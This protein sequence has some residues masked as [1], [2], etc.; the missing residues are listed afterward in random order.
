MNRVLTPLPRSIALP[1]LKSNASL[2][3]LFLLVQHVFT[4]YT[5]LRRGL[6]SLFG[7][8]WMGRAFSSAGM[9]DFPLCTTGRAD[10]CG[11][12]TLVM[13]VLGWNI[14]EA[15]MA[16]YYPTNSAAP[17]P[18]SGM[19]MGMGTGMGMKMTPT[20]MSSPLV[21]LHALT[22]YQKAD[23]GPKTRAYP[24]P[25]RPGSSLA[26]SA[27][28]STPKSPTAYTQPHSQP[29]P[30]PQSQSQLQRMTSPTPSH[31]VASPHRHSPLSASTTKIF[32]L[33]APAAPSSTG[34]FHESN[35]TDSPSK[36]GPPGGEFVLVDRE[37][38]E[39]VDNV[40]KGVRGKS[41]RVSLGGGY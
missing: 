39:W 29:Q 8:S 15:G 28:L 4:P 34:L 36:S 14:L 33:P 2:L 1:R 30:Q 32:N 11:T 19:G 7:H 26:Q 16:V 40:W 31:L 21:R 24:T 37:E 12:E 41:G 38:R 5:T 27:S 22:L 35:S 10:G 17:V 23:Q 6:I 13:L 3:F 25:D 9:C 18:V 20:K